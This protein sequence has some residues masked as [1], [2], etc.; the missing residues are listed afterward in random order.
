MI[1]ASVTKFSRVNWTKATFNYIVD[2]EQQVKQFQFPNLA[3][4]HN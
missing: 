3:T 2:S 1:I 4:I